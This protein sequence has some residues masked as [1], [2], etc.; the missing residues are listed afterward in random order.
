MT[1]DEIAEEISALESALY[2]SKL[3]A[4]AQGF[5]LLKAAEREYGWPLNYGELALLW[6]GGCIIRAV[7]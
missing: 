2:C 3:C 4:Y 6:R 1:A 5:A 7:S